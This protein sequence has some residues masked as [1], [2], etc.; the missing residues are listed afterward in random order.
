MF[1]SISTKVSRDPTNLDC[2]IREVVERK[3]Q[4]GH[5]IVTRQVFRK[6]G[7]NPEESLESVGH[8]DNPPPTH[9]ETRYD[10]YPTVSI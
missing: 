9:K 6:C 8:D 7:L 3:C 4:N 2:V 1:S 5:C 10:S